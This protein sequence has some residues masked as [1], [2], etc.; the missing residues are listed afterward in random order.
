MRESMRNWLY[1]GQH[2][3]SYPQ[4]ALPEFSYLKK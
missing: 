1:G 2:S 3:I 4:L